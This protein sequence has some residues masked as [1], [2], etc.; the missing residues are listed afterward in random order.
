MNRSLLPIAID[1]IAIIV[2][3]IRLL[4]SFTGDRAGGGLKIERSR[5]SL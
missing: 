1:A 4:S 5:G 2:I 3:G